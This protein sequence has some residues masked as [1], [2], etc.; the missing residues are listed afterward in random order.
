MPY[1]LSAYLF[2]ALGLFLLAAPWTGVWE[3]LV[4]PLAPTAWGPLARS[5]WLRG[6]VSGLG[7]LNLAVALA[8]GLRLWR[9]VSDRAGRGR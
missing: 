9:S 5:G 4:L 1:A 8:D 2:G 3:W 7:V 6:F